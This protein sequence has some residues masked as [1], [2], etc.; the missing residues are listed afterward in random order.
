MSPGWII[1]LEVTAVL[2]GVLAFGIWELL[3]LRR[4]RQ[5]DRDRERHQRAT[6]GIRNGSID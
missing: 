6:R 2:G 3:S 1:A 4:D 5:R